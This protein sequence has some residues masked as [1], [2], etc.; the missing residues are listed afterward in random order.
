MD[1]V[2]LF[3]AKRGVVKVVVE[4]E[5]SNKRTLKDLYDVQ[6]GEEIKNNYCEKRFGKEV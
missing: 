1:V 5:Y 6:Q 2:E 4:R 3:V